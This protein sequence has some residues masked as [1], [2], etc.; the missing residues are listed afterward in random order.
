MPFDPENKI[1]KI[2]VEGMAFEGRGASSN[3]QELFRK[4]WDLSK[5]HSEK[6]I[7]AHYLAR[8]QKSIAGK[9]HWDNTALYHALRSENEQATQSLP[10]LYLNIAKCHEDLGDSANAG[11]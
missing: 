3:A 7:A 1:V 4:A 6:F 10:S 11:I 8:H 5:N 9:L 2:C